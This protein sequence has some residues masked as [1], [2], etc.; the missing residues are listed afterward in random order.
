MTQIESPFKGTFDDL[1]Q[2]AEDLNSRAKSEVYEVMP[3][4]TGA[5]TYI[6]FRECP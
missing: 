1:Y 4:E 2:L 6:R 3:D 5:M